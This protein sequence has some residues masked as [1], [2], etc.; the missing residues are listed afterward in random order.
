MARGRLMERLDSWIEGNAD[1]AVVSA[2]VHAAITLHIVS[3]KLMLS[4][5]I[6]AAG[7]IFGRCLSPSLWRSCV[8]AMS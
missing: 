7:N 8:P 4:G 3:C 5:H 1:K 2:L 6:V